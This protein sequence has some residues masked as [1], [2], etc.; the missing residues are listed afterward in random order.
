MTF[1][2]WSLTEVSL[3]KNIKVISH[4]TD[5]EIRLMNHGVIMEPIKVAGQW[6]ACLNDNRALRLAHCSSISGSLTLAEFPFSVLFDNAQWSKRFTFVNDPDVTVLDAT[7]VLKGKVIH[8][9]F[10]KRFPVGFLILLQDS[11]P[12]FFFI[13]RSNTFRENGFQLFASW[14]STQ[15]GYRWRCFY[16]CCEHFQVLQHPASDTS[17]KKVRIR[18]SVSTPRKRR[19]RTLWVDIRKAEY[20]SDLSLCRNSCRT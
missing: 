7:M 2:N 14:W 4:L 11:A 17:R 13:L 12:T 9:V 8:R 16:F 5:C 1:I 3:V 10:A 15:D 18:Q 19:C 6:H 20:S